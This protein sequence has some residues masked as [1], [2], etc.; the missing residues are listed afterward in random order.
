M[1]GWRPT[2]V[3]AWSDV[4]M[5]VALTSIEGSMDLAEAMEARAF[6]SGPRTGTRRPAGDGG[7]S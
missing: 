6:G 3:R 7:T 1:R 4:L 2:G 5:P